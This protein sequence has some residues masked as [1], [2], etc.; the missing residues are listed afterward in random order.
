MKKKRLIIGI[1]VVVVIIAIIGEIVWFMAPSLFTAPEPEGF[2]RASGRIEGRTVEVSS[3]IPG[4]VLELL[5]DEGMELK[6]GQVIARMSSDE[7]EASKKGAEANLALWINRKSQA[8]L[9]LR[10]TEQRVA[11]SI[12]LAEAQLAAAQAN[13]ERAEAAAAQARKDFERYQDLEA[14]GV[15][16]RVSFDQAKLAH[17]SSQKELEAV[18]KTVQQ[19]VV[20][21]E[22]AKET[23]LTIELKRA[24]IADSEKMIETARAGLEVAESRLADAVIRAPIDGVVLERI[25]EPHEVINPGT[26]ILTMVNP[27]DLYL[28][29]YVP[30]V[31]MGSLR[32]GNPARIM[33]DAFSNEHFSAEV[34]RI[35]ERS[36]F[37]PK[38]VETRE[39]RINLVFEVKLGKIDNTARRLKPGMTAEA[40][41]KHEDS[42]SWEDPGGEE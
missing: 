13:Q 5:A 30:N 12:S 9:D 19:A 18:K 26:P 11:S 16:P 40:I 38:N 25:V 10:L 8:E 24:A 41:V 29:I 20:T 15:V 31:E 33:P 35:S 36:Q 4:R 1:V 42:R 27:D 28:K 2:V 3:K 7:L 23:R 21:L 22:L 17:T 34:T 39:Q 37:T 14:D 32:L 6:A